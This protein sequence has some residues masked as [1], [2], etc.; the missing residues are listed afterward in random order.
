M[1]HAPEAPSVLTHSFDN[2]SLRH[3]GPG[4]TSGVNCGRHPRQGATF[5]WLVVGPGLRRDDEKMGIF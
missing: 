5:P 1:R 3:A 2:L 4:S